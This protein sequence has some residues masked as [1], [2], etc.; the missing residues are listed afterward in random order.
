MSP[1]PVSGSRASRGPSHSL[2]APYAFAQDISVTVPQPATVLEKD[3]GLNINPLLQ[4]FPFKAPVFALCD[5][6]V[7][8][9]ERNGLYGPKEPKTTILGKD[10]IQGQLT[11]SQG[12]Q[13]TH[14]YLKFWY[15]TILRPSREL[16]CCSA[17]QFALPQNRVGFLAPALKTS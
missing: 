17:P 6:R 2:L 12:L 1:G 10:S 11:L 13:K 9:S 4:T 8:I 14:F 7:D 3:W 15:Q 5:I 16:H